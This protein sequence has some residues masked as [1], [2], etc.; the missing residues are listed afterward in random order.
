MDPVSIIPL[1]IA[2]AGWEPDNA[3]DF[4]FVRANGLTF[5]YIEAG[6]SEDPLVLC[7]HGFP[8]DAYTFNDLIQELAA[9]GYHAVAPFTRGYYPS[10]IPADNDYS[11]ETMAED[12]LALLDAFG[13]QKAVVIGHDWGAITAYAMAN[14]APERVSKL[15]TLAI[16]HPRVLRP[17]PKQLKTASQFLELPWGRSSVELASRDNFQYLDK[18][19]AKWSPTWHGPVLDAQSA[20]MKASFARPGRLEAA[21]GYYRS[22]RK[23]LLSPRRVLLYRKKTSVPTLTIHGKLD[24]ATLQSAFAST[25]RAFTGPYRL[26]ELPD[27]GHFV[28]LESPTATTDEVLHFLTESP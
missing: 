7:L 24:G 28:H 3:R 5:A 12:G 1:A 16:P 21:L 8:D 10:Q 20:R 6:K 4:S 18:T 9:K 25:P 22:F 26:V 2:F 19:Y 27:A 11:V 15:V 17:G 14:I 13:A 23:D